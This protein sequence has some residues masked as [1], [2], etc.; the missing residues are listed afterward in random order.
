MPVSFVNKG[1]L[2]NTGIM[3]FAAQVEAATECTP[4]LQVAEETSGRMARSMPAN[5][6]EFL[7]LFLTT[8]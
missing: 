6:L 2:V 4:M 1:T 7:A 5:H 8:P 3:N